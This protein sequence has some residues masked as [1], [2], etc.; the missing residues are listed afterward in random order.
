MRYF[1]LTEKVPVDEL[2]ADEAM[3]LNQHSHDLLETKTGHP[4]VD[5]A[6]NE[7]GEPFVGPLVCTLDDE[8]GQGNFPLFFLSPAFIA[9][10]ELVQ[11]LGAF[12]LKN[13]EIFP[14]VIIDEE[15]KKEIHD[16]Q[17]INVIGRVACANLDQS[18]CSSLSDDDDGDDESMRVVDSLVIEGDKIHGQDIF[19]V[20]E[21]TDCIVLSERLVKH[22]VG[23]GFKN[24]IFDEVGVA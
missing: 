11:A 5:C 20:H 21:D 6:E 9:K 14:V 24:V 17:L 7:D 10:K 23:A 13:I 12:G 16:Y 3:C 15:K 8:S 18:E 1:L 4:L 22:L 19:L 2:G